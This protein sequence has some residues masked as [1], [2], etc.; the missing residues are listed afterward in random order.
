M[1]WPYHLMKTSSMQLKRR[2]SHHKWLH[3]ETSAN[4]L[5]LLIF[6]C[7]DLVLQAVIVEASMGSNQTTFIRMSLQIC[8]NSWFL[9]LVQ[10]QKKRAEGYD[11]GDYTLFRSA[12]VSDFLQAEQPLDILSLVNEVC[13]ELDLS[14]NL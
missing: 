13:W 12:T 9:I 14:F 10:K 2:N 6:H 3:R 11:E 4:T 5:S 1:S 7:S 8:F